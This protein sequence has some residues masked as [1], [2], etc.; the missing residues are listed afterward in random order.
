MASTYGSP[1]LFIK[2]KNVWILSARIVFDTNGAPQLDT[3][4]SKGFCAVWQNTPTFTAGTTNSTTTVGTVSSFQGLFSGM[5]LTVSSGG[6][7][8]TS[9]TIGSIT[10]GS[11]TFTVNNQAILGVPSVQ[12]VA[13][14]AG[15]GTGQ[16]ILQLGQQ[17]A[18][19]LDTYNKILGLKHQFDMTT[20][21]AIGTATQQQLTPQAPSMI[22]IGDKTKVRTIPQVATSGSTDATITIQFGNGTGKNFQALAPA[23]GEAVRIIMVMGNST[24]P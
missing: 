9:T 3:T 13:G 18:T 23:A 8:N 16:Y 11:D 5:N 1:V 7:Y 19:R 10:A 15:G 4:Q 20:G 12:F 2:E 17:A 21:S 22:L 6:S 14:S 24:A